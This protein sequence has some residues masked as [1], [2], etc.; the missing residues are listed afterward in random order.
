MTNTSQARGLGWQ[1]STRLRRAVLWLAASLL[2]VSVAACAPVFRNH[3]YVPVEADLAAVEVGKDTRDTVAE[4][5]GRPTAAGLLNDHGWYYVQS[6][7]R[8]FGPREPQEI[9]RQVLAITFDD[10]GVVRNIERFG[11]EQGR[12]VSISSRV[13]E[14]NIKGIGL[15]RQLFSNFG[16]IGA[17]TLTQ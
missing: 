5:V 3:G 6:R 7:Y 14:S 1:A 2:A 10:G 8:H 12:V 15:I 16:R 11:L 4:K 13:T 9:E 17:D